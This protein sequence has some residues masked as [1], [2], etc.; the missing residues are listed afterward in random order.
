MAGDDGLE[1]P[2]CQNQ[3]LMP[4]QLGESPIVNSISLWGAAT[5]HLAHCSMPQ[6]IPFIVDICAYA[7]NYRGYGR[8]HSRSI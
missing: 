3:N 4:Y 2:K 8:S 1:P 7:I 6:I 5:H